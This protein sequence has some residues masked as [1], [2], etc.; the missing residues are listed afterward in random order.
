MYVLPPSHPLVQCSAMA[1]D[2]DED[3]IERYRHR[4][5]G[6][7]ISSAVMD[8]SMIFVPG[9]IDSL[10]SFVQSIW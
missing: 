9:I 8:V 2:H 10:N 4:Y 7:L 5:G 3:A 6:H 1:Y